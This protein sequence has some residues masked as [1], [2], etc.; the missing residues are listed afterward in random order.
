MFLHLENWLIERNLD[1]MIK[2][3][4]RRISTDFFDDLKG[5]MR[6]RFKVGHKVT[7]GRLTMFIHVKGEQGA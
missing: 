2:R 6:F 7:K 4:I 3:E 1:R 5:F